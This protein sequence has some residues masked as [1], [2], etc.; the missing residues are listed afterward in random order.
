MYNIANVKPRRG[1]Y[2]PIISDLIIFF[3]Q[4][5]CVIDKVKKSKKRRQKE[6]EDSFIDMI[7]IPLL[8]AAM[9]GYVLYQWFLSPLSW[10]PG[11]KIAALSPAWILYITWSEKRNRTVHALHEKYGPIVRL[12][13]SEVSISDPAYLKMIYSSG[14]YD[15][16]SFYG[17]YGNY[18]EEN[19][20]SSLD[21]YSH[22]KR[23]K[24]LNQLYSKSSVTNSSNE[25]MVQSKVSDLMSYIDAR[26][27]G[28][29]AVEVYN[30]F[31][32]LAMDVVTG[33]IF[34]PDKGSNFLQIGDFEVIESYRIQSAMWFWTTL[35]PFFYNWAVDPITTKASAIASEWNLQKC[36]SAKSSGPVLTQLAKHGIKDMSAY[37][38][39]QD[40]VAAGH[41][42]TGA[43]LTFLI[44]HLSKHKEIQAKL[45]QEL[46]NAESKWAGDTAT[47][48]R[49]AGNQGQVPGKQDLRWGS[50]HEPTDATPQVQSNGHLPYSIV[51][52]LPYLDGVVMETLRLYAAIP[53]AEPRVIPLGGMAY[54]SSVLPGGTVVSMQPWT[55][56]RDEQVYANALDFEPERWARGDRLALLKNFF[57]FG[58]GVR[59]C[60]GMNLALE[61]IK[62]SVAN[63]YL[64]Y[65]T[66]VACTTTDEMM[67]VV[68]KYTVH[69]QNHFCEIEFAPRA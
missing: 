22:I 10:V 44:W 23:R 6:T 64:K 7:T 61:E 63:I 25:S 60:I 59:M 43:T 20:F 32:A 11:P 21:K 8:L 37:S 27:M 69:P 68:D 39:I 62:L 9:I 41:E 42:T 45:Y 31:H 14:N 51:D 53:G 16:S 54:G 13:P 5:F 56:H 1:D 65:T 50:S 67:R 4:Y 19:A 17:Q 24:T 15:K 26:A 47:K 12:G 29:Q 58:S 2:L 52:K 38:E 35:M 46:K 3:H 28:N 57:A 49:M 66:S 48:S 30:M 18:N 33:F 55:L 36:L 34:G 40:H